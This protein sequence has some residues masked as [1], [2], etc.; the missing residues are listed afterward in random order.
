MKLKLKS[1]TLRNFK[2]IKD[3]TL[4][5]LTD[6]VHISGENASGKTTIMDAW[7]Y[8]LF[9]KDSSGRTDFNIKTLDPKTGEPYHRLEHEVSAELLVDEEIITLK[10]I[11]REK[12]TKPRGS[13]EEVFSGH[14]TEHYYNEVPLSQRDYNAKIEDLCPERIF[15]LI[16]NPMAFTS[17]P[18]QD[19]R[20]MLFDIAGE[21]DE[22]EIA[23]RNPAWMALVKTLNAHKTFEEYHR[24]IAMKKKRI[25]EDLEQIPARMDE[26]QRGM[27]A[28]EDWDAIIK[29]I[30]GKQKAV[31]AIEK[32][33]S[34]LSAVM[35]KEFENYRAK[36]GDINLKKI[37][38]DEIS[39]IAVR[40][41]R[42]KHQEL[43]DRWHN[44]SSRA[45]SIDREIAQVR[46]INEALAK[47]A[48]GYA[49]DRER[50]ITKWRE[51]NS[52]QVSF[53]EDEFVCPT[54]HRAFDEGKIEELKNSMIASFNENKRIHLERN[55]SEGKSTAAR[56]QSVKDSLTHNEGQIKE[57]EAEV[58]SIQEELA[59]ISPADVEALSSMPDTDLVMKGNKEYHSLKKEIEEAEKSL[60]A[61]AKPD[62]HSREDE[63]DKLQYEI[64]ILEATLLKRIQIETANKRLAQLTD[65]QEGLAEELATY[66]GIE[67]DIQN[68]TRAKI[69]AIENQVNSMF[70]IVK[71]KMFDLQ[72]NGQSV[73]TCEAIVKGVPYKDL[74][75]ACK[76][77]VGLDIINVF[78][79]NYNMYVPNWTDNAESTNKFIPTKS[80]MF[81]L[82]VTKDKELVVN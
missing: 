52:S 36:Q 54:C 17:L 26:V 13:K 75:H 31:K 34:D 10:K 47:E 71:F 50:L 2:G 73:E 51:I 67:F 82:Y 42:Q 3:L 4:A 21:V 24:E 81:K 19:Q 22:L 80:Q 14:E 35:N 61:P 56:L 77:N 63:K 44:L 1:I 12:W 57:L 6:E 64:R 74:N 11:Y 32:E 37:R 65:E 48:E 69:E 76:V 70:S 9:G 30:A 28:T 29:E 53:D 66:E 38:L 46:R 8:L 68:F 78:S 40:E 79:N 15:K 62:T 39:A 18:W 7:L 20:K 25:K 58:R 41:I 16:T 43:R 59:K 60:N 55:V 27:P 33:I 23:S 5:G 49:S 45:T 72:V